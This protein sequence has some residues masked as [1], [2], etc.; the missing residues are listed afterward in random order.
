[1]MREQE[2]AFPT[3]GDEEIRSLGTRIAQL[4]SGLGWKQTELARR[5][6]IHPTRLSRLENGRAIPHLHELIRLRHVLGA[7]LEEIVFGER[8]P[9]EA[10]PRQ[11]AAELEQ[12]GSPAEVEALQRLL[13]YLVLGYRVQQKE[14]GA[15]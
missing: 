5:A 10:T 6:A 1:M 14:R 2:R 13:G 7:G 3:T 9:S 11:L 15:C 8:A 4:R 12:V